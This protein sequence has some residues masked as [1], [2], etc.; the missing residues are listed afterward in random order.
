[1]KL[2]RVLKMKRL[3]TRV[4]FSS[5]RRCFVDVETGAR[6]KGITAALKRVFWSDYRFAKAQTLDA[7]GVGNSPFMKGPTASRRGTLVDKQVSSLIE[8]RPVVGKI[9]AFTGLAFR[10]MRE[11]NLRPV[12]S[13][14]VVFDES[15]RLATAVDILCVNARAQNVIVELKCSSDFKYTAATG[16]MK[17][18][19]A[20]LSNSLANQHI[21]QTLVTRELFQRTYGDKDA[22]ACILKIS[23][24][25][26][27]WVHVPRGGASLDTAIERLAPAR[28]ARLCTARAARLPTA[29]APRKAAAKPRGARP[30]V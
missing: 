12:A 11:A 7:V 15:R 1:M 19:F 23:Q 30:R 2:Q 18:E 9:H 3:Q 27:S 29:R 10:A 20:Q 6:F 26:A 13:Q 16:P 24:R 14:V 21:V 17:H 8:G 22:L 4:V 5:A 28:A 25:G